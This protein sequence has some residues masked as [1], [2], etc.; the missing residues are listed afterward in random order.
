MKPSLT[1]QDFE[2]AA[3]ILDCEVAAV[4][5]VDQIESRGAGFYPDGECVILFERHVFSRLTAGIFDRTNPDLSNKTP[6]GYGPSSAQPGRLEK[7]E[8][9]NRPAALSSCSWGRFQ[10]MG[11]NY[12]LAG[13]S[14]VDEMVEAMRR[15]EPEQL[16]AFVRFLQSTRLDVP[17][18]AKNWAGFAKGY[19][20]GGYAKNAYDV[21][22]KAAY[23]S[24]KR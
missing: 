16:A 21:K 20:G 14:N 12:K 8:T 10:I 13:F 23:E 1:Q 7:A 11:F 22:L 6:G 9:L 18:R 2:K 24:F 3:Q 4:K 19:N 5:A 17:L 15:G